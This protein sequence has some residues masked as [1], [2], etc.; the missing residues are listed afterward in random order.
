MI[1]NAQIP[2]ARSNKLSY[3][4]NST[5][6]VSIRT[7]N[8]GLKT[9]MKSG[10]V[11]F[12]MIDP[13][14][15]VDAFKRIIEYAAARGVFDLA[16]KGLKKIGR[17]IG[18]LFGYKAGNLSAKTEAA[19]E[20][21]ETKVAENLDG[22]IKEIIDHNPQTTPDKIVNIWSAKLENVIIPLKGNGYEQ[23]LNKVI[24]HAE[25]KTRLY[26]DL[27]MPLCETMAGKSKHYAIPNGINFFGPPGTGKTYFAEQLG[28]HYVEKGGYYTKLKLTTD[29]TKDIGIIDKAFAEAEENYN[30]SGNTKYTMIFIDE[31]E[32]YFTKND[33]AQKPTVARLLE[34]AN[35][36]KGRGAILVSTT[37]YLDKIEPSLLRTGRTDIRIPIGNIADYDLMD[38]I[39][40]YLKKDGLP[41]TFKDI[42]FEEV[43][44]SVETEKLQYKPQDLEGRLVREAENV[45]DYGGQM[46]TEFIKDALLQTK[47][48]F[49]AKEIAQFEADKAF[50]RQLGG[51]YEY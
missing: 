44:K 32:K 45:V 12:G 39:N 34:L 29:S 8:S 15:F 16:I 5:K 20:A 26:T 18:G 43:R 49:K 23:G 17:F 51:I 24:G 36:C 41:H 10:Q 31:I 48:E 40:Y 13:G 46:S 50:A 21:V 11:S 7:Q 27:F 30:K 9:Y 6:N 33:D 37:N 42:N 35:N 38:M 1:I 4:S 47:P 19:R 25:L 14:P 28:E 22:K 2:Q 3:Q